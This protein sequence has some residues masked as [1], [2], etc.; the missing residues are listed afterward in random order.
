MTNLTR[1]K[2]PEPGQYTLRGSHDQTAE[3]ESLAESI[4]SEAASLPDRFSDTTSSSTQRNVAY[5]FEPEKGALRQRPRAR[6]IEEEEEEEDEEFERHTRDEGS[7]ITRS[8]QSA[9]TAM[10]RDSPS[11]SPPEGEEEDDEEGERTPTEYL[12]KVRS[13]QSAAIPE[14]READA[15]EYTPLMRKLSSRS[16]RS[17]RYGGGRRSSDVERGSASKGLEPQ[18]FLAAGAG[19]AKRFEWKM[20]NP[21]TWDRETV[22]QKGVVQPSAALPAVFLGLLLNILDALSYGMILFPLGEPIF[23]QLGADGI[24]IFYVSTII[25]QL[26]YSCGGSIFKGGIGSEMIE[27]VPFFHRMAFMILARVG[28]DDTKAVF[29]T[30][31]LAYALSSILTGTVFFIM[32]A[33]GLGSLIGFFPRHILIGCIGGVGWFLVVTGLEVSARLTGSFEYDMETMQRLFQLDTVF[34]WT[35]PL[36]LAVLFLV[37]KRFIKSN[38]LVGGYFLSIALVFYFFKLVLGLPLDMLREKG[39]VFDAPAS[40]LPWYHFYTLYGE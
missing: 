17:Q 20:L 21:K 24:S 10:L 22:W 40:S 39:W 19:Y 32:G 5:S 27:V 18:P 4:Q 38:Y 8:G 25:A 11:T 7:L 33:S 34:L 16:R 14:D 26:V 9:L 1:S 15:T 31:I 12:F 6:P 28:T 36:L 13:S 2:P 3:I 30:T 37:I 29:A 35:S 23:A